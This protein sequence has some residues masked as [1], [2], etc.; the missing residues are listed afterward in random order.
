MFGENITKTCV[1][2]C[3]MNT[4]GNTVS[5]LCVGPLNCQ[6]GTFADDSTS[7]CVARCPVS[8]GMFG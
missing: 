8:L 1:K 5:N 3:P 7:K 4:F 6:T 2:N